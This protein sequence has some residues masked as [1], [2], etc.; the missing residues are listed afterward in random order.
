MKKLVLASFVLLVVIVS[1]GWTHK[2]YVGIFQVNY[3]SDKKMVQI[4]TRIFVDDLN[5]ALEKKHKKKFYV[6]EKQ[7]S[8]T[9]VAAMTKYIS[10]N[11][12][13]AVNGKPQVLDFRS[14]E[15][16]NNVVICYFRISG[17]AS[18]KSLEVTNKVLFDLVT[19]QQNIIQTNINGSKQNLLLTIDEPGGKLMF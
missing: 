4:T 18:V 9:D 8:E 1:S 11:F 13:L 3:A 5:N 17:V 16:E 7:V 19:E 6:G 10:D 15:M 12:R 14:Y 2:F